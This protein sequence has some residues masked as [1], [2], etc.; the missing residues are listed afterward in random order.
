MSCRADVLPILLVVFL[1]LT[2]VITYVMAVVLGHVDPEFPYISDTGTVPPESCVF[3][4]LLGLYAFICAFA[5]YIRYCQV[6]AYCFER[7]GLVRANKAALVLGLTSSFGIFLVA[8]V[9][10]TNQIVVHLCGAVLS[11]AGI[12][13]YFWFQTALSYMVKTIPGYC[14]CVR[15]FRLVLTL[16][17]LCCCIATLVCGAVATSELKDHDARKHR[18]HWHS[19]DG[20]FLWHVA[21]ASLEWVVAFISVVYFL[22]FIR[23]FGRF[24]FTFPQVIFTNM[25][26]LNGTDNDSLMISTINKITKTE[27]NPTAE[28]I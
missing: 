10:E 12:G 22:S 18:F 24:R 3:G 2:C 19:Q 7:R 11:F 8:N 21:S 15:H 23:E 5:I 16:I 25:A 6:A 17:H 9:Q 28:C 27:P 13:V 1:P 4:I 14:G 26:Q 20:G